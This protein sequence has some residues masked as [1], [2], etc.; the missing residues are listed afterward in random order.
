MLR[1][2]FLNSHGR[3]RPC[4]RIQPSTLR[5]PG[6]VGTNGAPS[7]ASISRAAI[8]PSNESNWSSPPRNSD[9]I[10]E[11]KSLDRDTPR[12]PAQLSSRS[13]RSA[14]SWRTPLQEIVHL[15]V[16]ET[17][18]EVRAT[19]PTGAMRIERPAFGYIPRNCGRCVEVPP[20]AVTKS[21][22]E[23]DE[24]LFFHKI[25]ICLGQANREVERHQNASALALLV[26]GM[27][28][29]GW[30]A[31]RT[32]HF[33]V[34]PPVTRPR[35]G[36]PSFCRGYAPVGMRNDG[37]PRSSLHSSTTTHQCWGEAPET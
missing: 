2:A 24:V 28:E 22:Q 11:R 36:Q 1:A 21:R 20:L 7:L 15:E 9:S 31:N 26:Q 30:V 3:L 29:R 10:A 33:D 16:V 6:S 8:V 32:W 23:R 14:R 27:Q 34:N 25:C 37:W 13:A 35:H 5:M 18:A 19:C 17:F 12:D 4:P